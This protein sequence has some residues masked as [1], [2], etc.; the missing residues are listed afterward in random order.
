MRDLSANSRV[1]PGTSLA[2]VSRMTE[3]RLEEMLDERFAT[4]DPALRGHREALAR[5]EGCVISLQKGRRHR[6]A[7]ESPAVLQKGT[8]DVERRISQSRSAKTMVLD[9]N[10]EGREGR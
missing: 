10:H 9:M 7:R 1:A 4:I 2:K 8:L 6:Q 5:V 3:T